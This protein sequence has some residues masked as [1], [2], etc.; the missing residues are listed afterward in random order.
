[1]R[2]F[3]INRGVI[4]SLFSLFN[5]NMDKSEALEKHTEYEMIRIFANA[6]FSSSI[7]VNLYV[8]AS[9]WIENKSRTLAT[10][11]RTLASS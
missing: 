11:L 6:I 9:S 10:G 7:N 5:N 3:T 1:M 4:I 8:I 2:P